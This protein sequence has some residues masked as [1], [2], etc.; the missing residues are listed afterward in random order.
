MSLVALHR[1]FPFW[2]IY[3]NL[4]FQQKFVWIVF[5]NGDFYKKKLPTL[6]K[7][8]HKS[9][10]QDNRVHILDQLS[11]CNAERQE[12]AAELEKYRECDPEVM[13]QLKDEAVL[14][15]EAANRWTGTFNL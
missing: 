5:C 6:L 11:K 1:F 15:K 8:S 14:A 7:L 2:R 12:L 13:L 3:Q 4:T 10:S 9:N